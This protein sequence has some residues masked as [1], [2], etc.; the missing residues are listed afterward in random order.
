M[1][2]GLAGRRAVVTGASKGI[3]FATAEALAREG[4][5]IVAVARDVERLEASAA[6]LSAATGATIDVWPG[7]MSD[8]TARSQLA[9]AHGDA[10]ILVNNAGAIPGGGLLDLTM[11]R[12]IESWQLKV[13]GYIHLTQLYLERMRARRAGVIVNVIGMAGRAPRYDYVC[14][15]TGNAGLIAFT[16]AVGARSVDW[17]VRV[18]G[19]NPAATRT[20]RIVDLAKARARTSLGDEARWEETLVDLPLGRPAEPA[21]I[22]DAIAVLA[23]P[24]CGYLS[25]TVIDVDG[26]GLFRS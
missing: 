1:D 8:A 11:E 13:F 19:I 26:G 17:G 21:E 22:A 15:A 3:G 6:R 18:L 14:G 24:R 25:G 23:S 10:D 7:D 2:L 12:W 16:S 20:D 4:C 9:A 5:S